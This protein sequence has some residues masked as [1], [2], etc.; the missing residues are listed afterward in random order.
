MEVSDGNCYD[1]TM[2]I[3][4]VMYIPSSNWRSNFVRGV[5]WEYQNWFIDQLVNGFDIT[6]EPDWPMTDVSEY[7]K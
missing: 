3:H 1:I 7:R 5:F 6:K 2:T 4:R